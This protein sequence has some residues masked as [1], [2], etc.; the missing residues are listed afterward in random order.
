MTS[1]DIVTQFT[2]ALR[3]ASAANVPLPWSRLEFTSFVDRVHGAPKRFIAE[4]NV[5]E[6]TDSLDLVLE[7]LTARESA[8]RDLARVLRRTLI[9]LTFLLLIAALLAASFNFLVTP[10][11]EKFR[12]DLTLVPSL[13]TQ[14]FG[15]TDLAGKVY[16]G[17][18]SGFLVFFTA[19]VFRGSSLVASLM[20]GRSYQADRETAA[21][22]RIA[23]RLQHSGNNPED[24]I[25]LACDVVD[26]RQ[27]I[28]ETLS[29]ATQR[30]QS[31]TNSTLDLNAMADSPLSAA[32]SRL[33]VLRNGL[34][35][36]MLVLVGGSAVL[37]YGLAVFWPVVA[38]V[39]DLSLAGGHT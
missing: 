19:V 4:L 23:D 9:Y 2:D 6:K 21:V 7:G 35:L 24:A 29:Q 8:R 28:R 10:T 32:A 14:H 1:S 30:G 17:L 11:I 34:P 13:P 16:V 12:Q 33:A 5:F 37:S 31:A 18:C 39:K 22:L 15:T 3:A 27:T 36:L 38:F 25:S 26:A 20:G